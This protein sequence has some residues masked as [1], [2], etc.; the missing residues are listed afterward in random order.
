[1]I[2][3][4][5]PWLSGA[6]DGI[7]HALFWYSVLLVC[8]TLAATWQRRTAIRSQGVHWGLVALTFPSCSTSIAALQYSRFDGG[9]AGPGD[10]PAWSQTPLLTYA[11]IV[12]ALTCAT[13]IAVT[14]GVV[15][16]EL[17]RAQTIVHPQI[18]GDSPAK[19]PAVASDKQTPENSDGSGWKE[20][21]DPEQPPYPLTGSG[22][23]VFDEPGSPCS[24]DP[25]SSTDAMFSTRIEDLL[26]AECKG[27]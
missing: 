20:A 27:P 16:Q 3:S 6:L 26:L 4:T 12:S 23:L 13:V 14:V 17:K 19:Q 11:L 25:R 1:M 2:S 21:C 5:A 8:L 15:R 7:S 24:S 10:L 18:G 22:S 9:S